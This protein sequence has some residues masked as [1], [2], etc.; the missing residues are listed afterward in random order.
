MC[1]L[2]T[3]FLG[4]LQQRT[5][6][7]ADEMTEGSKH[8]QGE[9]SQSRTLKGRQGVLPP[10]KLTAEVNSVARL[11]AKKQGGGLQL[12]ALSVL[13]E[14]CC[15]QLRRR[16]LLFLSQA[17][18]AHEYMGFSNE[19]QSTVIHPEP[20]CDFCTSCSRDGYTIYANLHPDLRVPSVNRALASTAQCMSGLTLQSLSAS[21]NQDWRFGAILSPC[22]NCKM[23][24]SWDPI[25]KL[26]R[27]ST[28]SYLNSQ[29]RTRCSSDCSFWHTQRQQ[30]QSVVSVVHLV[31]SRCEQH[32]RYLLVLCPCL[33]YPWDPA[34]LQQTSREGSLG[35]D[36]PGTNLQYTN[37]PGT[38]C[39]D[40]YFCLP[41]QRSK[42]TLC[43][44]RTSRRGCRILNSILQQTGHLLPWPSTLQ[45]S[46]RK[47]QASEI[48]TFIQVDVLEEMVICKA[49]THWDL[50]PRCKAATWFGECP[51]LKLMGISPTETCLASESNDE[52]SMFLQEAGENQAPCS[53]PESSP[54]PV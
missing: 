14:P 44:S 28:N 26:I 13:D 3:P 40:H 17:H 49:S 20:R 23:R 12:P 41:W 29:Y 16:L 11:V 22:T 1:L 4:T 54:S 18:L 9:R 19:S 33:A 38:H 47:H 32:R 25:L 53:P 21:K 46:F 5:S 27:H 34:F 8:W 37:S 43:L 36:R 50:T 15:V 48:P 52:D 2:E 31:C 51:V 42:G 39:I 10:G 6:Y 35:G 45:L 24:S 30:S 7:S